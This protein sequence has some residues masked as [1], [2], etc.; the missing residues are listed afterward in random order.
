[1]N[2]KPK[3]PITFGISDIRVMVDIGA[4]IR[5]ARGDADLALARI[6][7]LQREINEIV[8]TYENDDGSPKKHGLSDDQLR[9]RIERSCFLA[10]ERFCIMQHSQ[11]KRCSSMDLRAV[12]NENYHKSMKRNGFLAT[13]RA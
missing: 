7:G 13:E 5:I 11:G 12:V 3:T 8:G 9:K 4:A 6:N 10:A 1:M 2:N